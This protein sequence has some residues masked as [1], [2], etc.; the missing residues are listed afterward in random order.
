MSAITGPDFLGLQVR[1]V[2]ASAK[3]YEEVVGLTRADIDVPNA[4]VFATEPI[5]FAVRTPQ[6]DLDATD[7]LGWGTAIWFRSEDADAAHARMV[8]HGA[9]IAVEPFDGMFGR[10]FSFVDPDGYTITVHDKG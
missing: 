10:T 1:D 2:D 8:E 5:P 3:F 9:T 4:T 7:R 6:V